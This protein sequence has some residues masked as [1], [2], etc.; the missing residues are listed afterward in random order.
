LARPSEGVR[1]G[2]IEMNDFQ[3]RSVYVS[4]NE[5]VVCRPFET[6]Y[7]VWCM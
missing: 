1:Q 3:R 2:T 4:L 7:V 6:K 5:K